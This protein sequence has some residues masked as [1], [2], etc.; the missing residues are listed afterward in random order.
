MKTHYAPTMKVVGHVGEHPA[1]CGQQLEMFSANLSTH[2]H[3][4]TCAKCKAIK[5]K[6]EN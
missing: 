6:K 4:I 3:W 5:A 2:D 1:A